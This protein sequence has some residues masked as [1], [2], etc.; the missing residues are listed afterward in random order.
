[1]ADRTRRGFLRTISISGAMIGVFGALPGLASA[2]EQG[3]PSS[4]PLPLAPAGM[5]PTTGPGGGVTLSTPLVVYIDNPSSG[6]GVIFVGEQSI[7]FDNPA[8]VQSLRTAI[9]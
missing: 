1:M 6:K 8:I 9:G 4:S 5:A 3:S 2:Q 7:A